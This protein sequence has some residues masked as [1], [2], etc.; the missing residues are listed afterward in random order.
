MANFFNATVLSVLFGLV[1]GLVSTLWFGDW[2]ATASWHRDT[3]DH[4]LA[5]YCP[6]NG[7]WARKGECK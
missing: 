2:A 4:N 6:N 1:F 7:E 5:Q 3:V